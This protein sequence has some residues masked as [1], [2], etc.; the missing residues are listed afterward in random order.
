M[1]A[2]GGADLAFARRA[3]RAPIELRVV[4]QR[5]G[6]RAPRRPDP[7]CA[8]KPCAAEGADLLEQHRRIDAP[9]RRRARTSRPGAARPT[10]SG[11][12]TYFLP[13]TTSV[14]PALAP[15]AQRTTTGARLGQ[16]VDDLALALVAP[17]RADDDDDGHFSSSAFLLG[18]FSTAGAA[19]L[20][21]TSARA[22]THRARRPQPEARRRRA[23][24]PVAR[25]ASQRLRARDQHPAPRRSRAAPARPVRPPARPRPPRRRSRSRP[26]AGPAVAPSRSS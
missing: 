16:Q 12:C 5:S 21:G 9:C 3:P 6:A 23:C 24:R 4:R 18:A 26:R 19:R 13:S 11:A 10:G 2:L 20:A 25:R 1:P 17:L 15:P 7:R 14:W 8:S 22:R